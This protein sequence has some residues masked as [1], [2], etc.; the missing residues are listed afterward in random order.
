VHC[1]QFSAHVTSAGPYRESQLNAAD[2]VQ[3]KATKFENRTLAQRRQIAG[4]C[5]RFRAYIGERAWKCVGDRHK[6]HAT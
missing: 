3:K 1:E 2:R 5:A 4:M 6:D